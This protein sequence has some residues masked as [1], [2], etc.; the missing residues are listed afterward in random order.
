[1]ERSRLGAA[2][3]AAC[4][5]LVQSLLPPGAVAAQEPITETLL[6]QPSG[7]PTAGR[8]WPGFAAAQGL[9][10]GAQADPNGPRNEQ[11]DTG[12]TA[13]PTGAPPEPITT[14]LTAP[15][16]GAGSGGDLSAPT[17]PWMGTGA[18]APLTPPTP[19]LTGG[20]PTSGGTSLGGGSPLGPGVTGLPNM[21]NLAAGLLGQTMPG[22][23]GMGAWVDSADWAVSPVLGC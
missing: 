17:V 12:A 13:E 5:L 21:G 23:G 20:M 7:A 18:P 3:S 15:G 4:A 11:V 6:Q 16:L 1:M 19:P 9:D 22:M 2:L 10:T 8:L 14:S